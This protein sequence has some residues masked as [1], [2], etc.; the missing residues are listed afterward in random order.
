MS[1]VD[2]IFKPGSTGGVKPT[3]VQFPQGQYAYNT[4][5]NNFAPSIG[6]AWSVPASTGL[7]SKLLGREEGDSVIRGGFAMAYERPGMSNF[8]DVFGTNPGLRI[9]GVTDRTETNGNLAVGALLRNPAQVSTPNFNTTP[10]YP[11]T[12]SIATVRQHHSTRTCRSRTRSRGPSAGSASCRGTRCSKRA[13]SAAATSTTGC[14][15]TS[16]RSTSSR[17]GS[18]TSSERRRRTCRPTSPPAEARRSPI[19]ACPAPAPL[20]IILAYFSGVNAAGAG[21]PSKYNSA[22]FTDS[23]F[24]NAL[25]LL[26][27]QPCCSTSTTTPS[28]AW[29]LMNSA[30]R[31]TNALTAGLPAN[32]FVANPDVLGGAGSGNL[33]SNFITNGSR[34]ALPARRSSS[35][36]SG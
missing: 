24:L 16:T 33:G 9:T 23:T 28:F 20:P 13:T 17:T 22:S 7:L 10:S 34:H 36:A 8:T 19:P 26:N 18:S 31:R 4:D 11:I 6:A 14:S 1:G 12:A 15:R 25:A 32:L 27:P 3:F 21:D 29:N 35:S 5:R 2:N 30:A